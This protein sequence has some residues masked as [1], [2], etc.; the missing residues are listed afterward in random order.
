MYIIFFKY[1]FYNITSTWFNLYKL[2]VD[3]NITSYK[4]KLVNVLV[5]CN[6]V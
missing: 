3:K 2:L 5:A 6:V 4:K 1:C